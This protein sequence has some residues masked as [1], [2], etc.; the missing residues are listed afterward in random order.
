MEVLVIHS[1]MTRYGV[2]ACVNQFYCTV[3]NHSSLVCAAQ[4]QLW[5]AFI[6]DHMLYMAG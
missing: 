2:C 5:S 1:L 6:H 4:T 3:Q